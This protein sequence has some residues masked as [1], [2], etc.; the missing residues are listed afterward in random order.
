MMKDAHL[1]KHRYTGKVIVHP[2]GPDTETLRLLWDTRDV[3]GYGQCDVPI[4]IAYGAHVLID[5]EHSISNFPGPQL[6]VDGEKRWLR[7]IV[8]L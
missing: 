6:M 3:N 4:I 8:L 5:I 2:G 1:A 7:T